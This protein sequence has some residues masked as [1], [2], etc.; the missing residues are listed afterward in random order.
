[1]AAIFPRAENGCRSIAVPDALSA[2]T[3]ARVL[4]AAAVLAVGQDDHGTADRLAR[5]SLELAR[6]T[7]DRHTVAQ[8]Y[9]ALGIAAIEAG[10]SDQPPT[11]FD[12]AFWCVRSWI[13]PR[14][15]RSRWESHEG[16]PAAG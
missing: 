3:H 15:R 11:T 4:H 7:G 2:R 8:A 14:E 16:R 9:N 5:Q 1:M 6:A 13:S 12:R 10:E